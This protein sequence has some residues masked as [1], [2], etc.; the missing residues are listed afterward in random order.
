[1]QMQ[2]M[3]AEELLGPLNSV[4]SKNAP[5]RLYV[6]GDVSILT[7]GARVS[8][9]GS[10]KA[11]ALGLGE[12][13]ALASRLVS[14]GIVVVSG[15][16][17]GIDTAAHRATIEAGGKTIAVLG[18]SL[19][20]TFPAS[21]RD[22]QQELIRDHLVITQFAPG[23]P[24]RKGNFPMRNRTMALLSDAT[25]IVEAGDGSGSLHQGW[26]A[27]RLGR[28]LFL[29]E[30]LFRDR[31]LKWPAEMAGYGA[32]SLSIKELDVLLD[33]VPPRPCG[34]TAELAF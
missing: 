29:M 6:A 20:E 34:A 28:P 33:H 14:H 32:R 5:P 27:L 30:P 18:T 19:D 26:E 2:D 13:K 24:A 23:V 25:V 1:M 17:E 15:L 7:H 3:T 11:T 21:N 12:V 9:V 16:A 31:T 10:R 22:L 4:E 8:L